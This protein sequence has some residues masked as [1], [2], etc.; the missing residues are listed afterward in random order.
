MWGAATNDI[1]AVG[2]EGQLSHWNGFDWIDSPSPLADNARS[3]YG[4]S[5]NEL[6]LVGGRSAVLQYRP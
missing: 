5:K 1:W 4:T 6:W 3:I 2:P